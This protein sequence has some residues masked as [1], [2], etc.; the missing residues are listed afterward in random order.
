MT[1]RANVV[2]LYHGDR[3]TDF[4]T[5]KAAGVV[6][7]IH[8]A[9]QGGAALAHDP[10]YAVRRQR[11]LAAGLLWGAYH[12]MT[13]DD[14]EQQATAFLA[15]AFPDG[16]TSPGARPAIDNT[17]LLAI[18]Y[19]PYGRR[20]PSLDQLRA[21]LHAIEDKA[22]RKA[23]IYSGSLIKDTLGAAA[24]EYLSRHR[25]WLAEYA[26]QW[27]MAPLTAWQRPW[28]WQYSGDGAGPTPHSVAGI[29]GA[30]GHVDLNCYDGSDQELAKEWAA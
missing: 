12:F 11:A 3:V 17:T 10:L 28:L 13:D 15:S 20:T 1:I 22:G 24:D 21:M 27:K 30:G 29:Q 16:G 2:D 9:H 4:A 8:K 7:V 19:E 14:P 23:V 6:G 25:L 26:E 18:D 5:A